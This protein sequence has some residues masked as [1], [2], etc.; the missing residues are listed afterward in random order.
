[1]LQFLLG[2][3][4]LAGVGAETLVRCARGP[5][6]RLLIVG[7]IIVAV[8]H[9]SWQAYRASFVMADDPANP[10]VYAQTSADVARLADELVMLSVASGQDTKMPIQVIW[11]DVY[12]WPLPWYVRQFEQVAWW[13][14]LPANVSAPIVMAAPQYD[15][16]LTRELGDQYLMT[17]YYQLRPEVLLQLWVR[18]DVWEAHL[19]RLGRI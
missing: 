13:T 16:E 10:Y 7:V 15:A 4:L 9:L 6:V 12:Y 14:K 18:I 11:S 8:T 3:I 5:A 17:G 1:M 2:L 19:R